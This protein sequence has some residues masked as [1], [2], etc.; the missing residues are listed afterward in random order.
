[1]RPTGWP[2]S[3]GLRHYQRPGFPNH[4]PVCQ[5]DVGSVDQ[6]CAAMEHAHRS[7]P[8]RTEH[9]YRA[10]PA[11][12]PRMRGP[13]VIT[14][15]GL[16]ISSYAWAQAQYPRYWGLALMIASPPLM[17][18]SSPASWQRILVCVSRLAATY[19]LLV[20]TP[21]CLAGKTGPGFGHPGLLVGVVDPSPKPASGRHR[22]ADKNCW[23]LVGNHGLDRTGSE[24][25]T[26]ARHAPGA[27]AKAIAGGLSDAR[28]DSDLIGI[29][30]PAGDHSPEARRASFGK[31][32]RRTSPLI[33]C[34]QVS[35]A[36]WR[37]PLPRL[38]PL[39]S[40]MRSGPEPLTS[41]RQ[42]RPGNF[43]YTHMLSFFLVL[44]V[45]M[46]SM[47]VREDRLKSFRI[48]W[49]ALK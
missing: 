12:G 31:P 29:G 21:N 41:I 26:S 43:E 17:L 34:D 10:G 36:I 19:H 42:L 24:L 7:M 49:P 20:D 4:A 6:Q 35:C 22:A 2:F 30:P 40:G 16:R 44:L 33:S 5:R 18:P 8:G 37:K 27:V 15:V 1:M 48:C 14:S 45:L 3:T 46:P 32:R 11:N 13:P 25:M 23:R 38:L 28:S 47:S 9:E 39:G